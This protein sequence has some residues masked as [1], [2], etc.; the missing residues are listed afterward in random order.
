[1]LWKK[2]FYTR[3]SWK[4]SDPKRATLI[5]VGASKSE[6]SKVHKTVRLTINLVESNES[7]YPELNYKELVIAEEVSYNRK[8]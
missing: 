7:K 6:K 5:T 3:I 4:M 8:S 1:M 2:S